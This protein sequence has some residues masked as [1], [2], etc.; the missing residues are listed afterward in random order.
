MDVTKI[1]AASLLVPAAAAIAW[2]IR[3][4]PKSRELH[5]GRVEV[6]L[7]PATRF[8]KPLIASIATTVVAGGILALE[9]AGLIPLKH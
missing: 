6:K 5:L 3:R 8:D 1:V 9:R 7:K 4:A 2:R